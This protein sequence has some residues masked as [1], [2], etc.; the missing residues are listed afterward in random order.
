MSILFCG[1]ALNIFFIM[2]LLFLC[3]KSDNG[4]SAGRYG[5]MDTLSERDAASCSTRT[6]ERRNGFGPERY[7]RAA[8][9]FYHAS[10]WRHLCVRRRVQSAPITFFIL[11]IVMESALLIFLSTF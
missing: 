5:T 4:E 10:W 6:G 11:L 8:L 2:S 1:V 7:K 3:V 9:F